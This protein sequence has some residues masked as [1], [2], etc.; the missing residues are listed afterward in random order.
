MDIVSITDPVITTDFYQDFL[1][2]YESG[3][4]DNQKI[5]SLPAGVDDYPLDAYLLA[6]IR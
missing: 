2:M 3:I 5:D 6:R 1:Q 4:A